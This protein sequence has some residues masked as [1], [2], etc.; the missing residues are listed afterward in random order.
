MPDH[1]EPHESG[2]GGSKGARRIPGAGPNRRALERTLAAG[3]EAGAI[4]VVAAFAARAA[5]VDFDARRRVQPAGRNRLR[6][7]TRAQLGTQD[8]PT[9]CLKMAKRLP[10]VIRW[11]TLSHPHPPWHLGRGWQELCVAPSG[12]L[13]DSQYLTRLAENYTHLPI[14]LAQNKWFSGGLRRLHCRR[15]WRRR[16]WRRRLLFCCMCRAGRER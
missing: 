16:R 6:K 9:R 2:A 8:K 4:E 7:S 10:S 11:A 3:M 15:R 12:V 14:A 1:R 5:R 13:P